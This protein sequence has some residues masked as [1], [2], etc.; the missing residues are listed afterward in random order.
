MALNL[1]KLI[2]SASHYHVAHRLAPLA[3]KEHGCFQEE[4]LPEV[5]IITTNHNEDNLIN[6]LAA[7][8]VHIGL[9][10][11][12]QVVLEAVHKRGLNLCFI[13]GWRNMPHWVVFGAKGMKSIEDV[14]GKRMS[15]RDILG[16]DAVQMRLIFRRLGWDP[17]K[18]VQWVRGLHPVKHAARALRAGQVDCAYVWNI[19]APAL[20]EEGY[21]LLMRL[22][23]TYYKDGYPERSVVSTVE[24][25]EQHPRVVIGFLKGLTRGYRMIR[26]QPRNKEYV[27]DLERRT[28]AVD[29]D[30]EERAMKLEH[31]AEEWARYPLPLDGAMPIKGLEIV[32]SQEQEIG[33]LPAN[34]RA[35]QVLRLECLQQAQRELAERQDL[36]A[37][38]E[39]VQAWVD[40]VGY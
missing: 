26:D 30:P 22:D 24:L 35:E 8:T 39:R 20:L 17:D 3:A 4:V 18:D 11:K 34:F 38:L 37:E 29:A 21:P 27:D 33:N 16:I 13:A 25:V 23:H 7:G 31:T 28:R 32:V 40:K 12:P 15:C 36:R 9:D 6:A 19:E 14:K 10:A 1:D 2:V 5:E